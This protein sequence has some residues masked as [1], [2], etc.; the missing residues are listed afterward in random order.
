MLLLRDDGKLLRGDLKV[1]TP[2]PKDK[3]STC[4]QKLATCSS[5]NLAILILSLQDE[6]P[7]PSSEES[8]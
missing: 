1:F 8:I 3:D 6:H 2:A 5:C 7:Y 4:L